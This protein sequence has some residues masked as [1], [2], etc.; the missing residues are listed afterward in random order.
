MLGPVF[1]FLINDLKHSVSCQVTTL[2]G[3]TK[4]NEVNEVNEGEGRL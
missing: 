3:G 4:V 2:A 1:N